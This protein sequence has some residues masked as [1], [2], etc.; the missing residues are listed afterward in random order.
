MHIKKHAQ[1]SLEIIIT[2]GII[3]LVF[4]ASLPLISNM[5]QEIRETKH[6]LDLLQPCMEIANTVIAVFNSGDGSSDIFYTGYNA[7]VF[8]AGFV[9]VE[10]DVSC[11]FPK[12]IVLDADLSKGNI[13]IQNKG[14]SIEVKNV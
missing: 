8:G 12:N 9:I 1:M 6:Y 2:I 7:S 10:N 4:L 14:D 13:L 11:N 5:G 3:L